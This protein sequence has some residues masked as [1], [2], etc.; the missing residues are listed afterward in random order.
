MKIK[1]YT[2]DFQFPRWLKRALV[3]GAI[4]VAVLFGLVAVVWAAN[5]T[6]PTT[7]VKAGV[8]I[9]AQP[10]QDDLV[11]L[12]ARVALLEAKPAPLTTVFRTTTANTSQTWYSACLNNNGTAFPQGAC[13]RLAAETCLGLGYL[14]GWFEGELVNNSAISIV[15]IK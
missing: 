15:C 12:N 1:V 7:F 14:A 13:G 10:L 2:I 5:W 11:N 3:Y 8:Q 6:D 9:Q 4:P